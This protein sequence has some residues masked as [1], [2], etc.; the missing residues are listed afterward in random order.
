M[1]E[2]VKIQPLNVI[3]LNNWCLLSSSYKNFNNV[4]ITTE[5]KTKTLDNEVKDIIGEVRNIRINE[6]NSWLIGDY[7]FNSEELETEY[8]DK[9]FIGFGCGEIDN[10]TV[11][12]YDLLCVHP[13]EDIENYAWKDLIKR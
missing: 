4:P 9:I 11:V 6:D 1:I 5:D 2:N 3:N 10:R 7:Y 12:N 13:M 8:K